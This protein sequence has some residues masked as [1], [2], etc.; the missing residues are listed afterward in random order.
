MLDLQQETDWLLK[1][2]LI[3]SRY[4]SLTCSVA[5]NDKNDIRDSDSKT[6]PTNLTIYKAVISRSNHYEERQIVIIVHG[7]ENMPYSTVIVEFSAVFRV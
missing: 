6:V 7:T 1:G 2:L 5:S 3:L 4:C